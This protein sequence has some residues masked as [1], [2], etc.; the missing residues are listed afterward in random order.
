MIFTKYNGSSVQGPAKLRFIS[1]CTFAMYLTSSRKIPPL[2]STQLLS[3]GIFAI[4]FSNR[5]SLLQ[6]TELQEMS[7]PVVLMVIFTRCP[8]LHPIPH[9]RCVFHAHEVVIPWTI[10]RNLQTSKQN[11]FTNQVQIT[12]I[13][14]TQ[15]HNQ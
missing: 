11:P 9:T 5:F 4:S 7:W 14:S 15:K 2:I 12:T 1:T 8:Q 10:I 6:V 3:E 13:Q